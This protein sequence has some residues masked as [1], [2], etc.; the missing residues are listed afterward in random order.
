MNDVVSIAHTNSGMRCMVMPGV[1]MFRIVTRKF[2]EPRMDEAPR[3]KTPT[4]HRLWPNGPRL[5]SGGYDVQP[6]S[7][8]PVANFWVGSG[9]QK[10][11]RIIS[12]AGKISQNESA[13]ILGK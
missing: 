3:M 6:A 5:L 8:A 1:R 9:S 2:I 4:N 13:L 11:A 7:A 10:P 12:P